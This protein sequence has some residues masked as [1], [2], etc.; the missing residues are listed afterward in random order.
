MELIVL[1]IALN[2]EEPSIDVNYNIIHKISNEWS[3][4]AMAMNADEKTICL[5]VYQTRS[6]KDLKILIISDWEK[7]SYCTLD[8]GLGIVSVLFF[9]QSEKDSYYFLIRSQNLETI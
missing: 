3:L 4:V 5:L 9:Y 7:R 2:P 8:T 1:D 6:P